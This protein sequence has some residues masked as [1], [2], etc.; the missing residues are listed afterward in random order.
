M[1][2]RKDGRALRDLRTL[3]RVGITRDLTDGQLLERFATEQGEA[4]EQ[5]FSTLVERHGPMVLR[6]CKSVLV[7]SHDA[8][9]AFQ[10]TFLVLVKRAHGLWL[11]DSLGPWLYQ[12]AYRTA[13]CARRTTARRR[14]LERGAAIPVD[15]G[16]T[17]TADDLGPL[18]HEELDRLPARF[19][20]PIVLCD[21]EGLTHE[22]AARHLG[23]PVGTVKSRLTRGRERLRGR[24]IRRGVNPNAGLIA[25]TLHPDALTSMLS[26]SLLDGTT[27]AAIQFV[28]L[29]T[30][31][32]GSVT[33]LAQEVLRNMLFT[34]GLKI[35]AVALALG[36]TGSGISFIGPAAESG[37]A[38]PEGVLLAQNTAK[39]GVEQAPENPPSDQ[40]NGKTYT[41]KPGK[42]APAVVEHGN[43]ETPRSWPLVNRVESNIRIL[44]I[45]PE[46]THV[47]KGDLICEL[48]AG[49]LRDQLMNQRI[50]SQEKK[51]AY[52]NTKLAR[53]S[54]EIAV[55]EAAEGI[56]K[57]ESENLKRE[58]AISDSAIQKA[59]SRLD[60]TRLVAKRIKESLAARGDMAEPPELVAELDIADRVDDAE[61]RVMREEATLKMTQDRLEIL[62]VYT[63]PKTIK[64]LTSEVEKARS[65]ELT[66]ER[67]L[68]LEKSVEASL[69]RQII[70]CKMYAPSEGMVSYART[71]V[72][73]KIEEGAVVSTQ[74]RICSIIDLGAPIEMKIQIPEALI[75]RV[76]TKDKAQIRVDAFPGE[77]MTGEV[78]SISPLANGRPEDKRYTTHIRVDHPKQGA[79][80]GMSAEVEIILGE[81]DHVLSIPKRALVQDGFGGASGQGTVLVQRQGGKS[82]WRQ[83]T[84]GRSN[85][86]RV[87]IKDGLR[88][89]DVILLDPRNSGLQ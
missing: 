64:S 48:D 73:D 3:F 80:A 20:A 72:P 47:K 27:K 44:T 4:A 22:L 56:L 49:P 30:I 38:A 6:V 74:Q 59:K 10:A 35:A 78:T 75:G 16:R 31:A 26:P 65:N 82:E 54:A 32:V 40:G 86:Q 87:E 89:G 13:S 57:Q 63:K 28:S 76:R 61:Q 69:E 33:T 17:E 34:S 43:L 62:E 9:D 18:L 8:Q 85:A 46:G 39:K 23:W 2:M 37:S 84:L 53:E 36:A 88:E 52:Q 24:L 50:A 19:R 14:R 7:D 29:R 77:V 41:I 12:V 55:T 15:V 68:T 66:K 79:K 60:R 21:L 83:V 11:R 71:S 1:T 5:A 70:Q 58:I 81:L 25:M 51:A 42:F 67:A 45:V